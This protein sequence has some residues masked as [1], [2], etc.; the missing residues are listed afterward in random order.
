[1][2]IEIS[3][4]WRFFI[5]TLRCQSGAGGEQCQCDTLQ[6][7]RLVTRAVRFR[8]GMKLSYGCEQFTQEINSDSLHF[9][10]IRKFT[11]TEL[12]SELDEKLKKISTRW[13]KFHVKY[14][15]FPKQNGKRLEIQKSNIL[16]CRKC[17]RKYILSLKGHFFKTPYKFNILLTLFKY[18]NH[19]C[20]WI[21][22]L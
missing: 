20:E 13:K 2:V 12:G 7:N 17:F 5:A 15:Q 19:K 10:K 21:G 14:F 4:L 11:L 9:E 3:L 6:N 18:I 16:I 8:S 1:M 22:W